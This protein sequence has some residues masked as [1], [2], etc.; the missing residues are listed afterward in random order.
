MTWRVP[1]EE[2]NEF[3]NTRRSRKQHFVQQEGEQS[4]GEKRGRH[5]AERVEQ[6]VEKHGGS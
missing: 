4:H 2:A 5:R 6:K 1:E 3:V